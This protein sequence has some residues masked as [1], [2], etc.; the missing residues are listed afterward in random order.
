MKAHA[1]EVVLRVCVMYDPPCAIPSC[2]RSL[3]IQ[4]Y[5][6]NVTCYIF[7]SSSPDPSARNVLHQ[8]SKFHWASKKKG[9]STIRRSLEDEAFSKESPEEMR[10]DMQ[11]RVKS[12]L[13]LSVFSAV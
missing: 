3:Q 2:K 4:N 11:A 13:A 8:R 9:E 6:Y 12:R 1:D 7:L 10:T 5:K